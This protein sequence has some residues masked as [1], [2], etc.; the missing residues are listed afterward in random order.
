MKEQ[1]ALQ[2]LRRGDQRALEALMDRYSGYVTAILCNLARGAL[3]VEDIEELASDVFVK[4]WNSAAALDPERPLKPWLA[5]VARTTLFSRLRRQ[6]I[7]RTALEE[8][9]LLISGE[10]GP[11]SLAERRELAG[12]VRQAVAE[13][14]E[15]DRELF[16]RYYYFGEK[17]ASAAGRLGLN[18]QTTKTRLRRCRLRLQKI[19]RERGCDCEEALD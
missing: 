19:F 16:I 2:K 12:M 6:E 4:L 3:A 17:L 8:D 1:E 10:P 5:Q 11:E 13:L 15:P 14:G 18:Q 9:L 7:P